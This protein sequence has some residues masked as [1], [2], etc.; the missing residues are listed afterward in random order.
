MK[1]FIKKRAKVL[2]LSLLLFC[3]LM[4]LFIIFFNYDYGKDKSQEIGITFSKSY[5]QQ[6]DLNWQE[7]YLSLLD[8]LQIK[9]VRLVAQWNEVEPTFLE[10]DFVDLDWQIK[11]AKKRGV[12]VVLAIGRRTPRWPE[13]HDPLWLENLDV[14]KVEQEQ[15]RMV[16][17]VV[18]HFKQFDNIKMCSSSYNNCQ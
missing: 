14:K 6:L 15:L 10:Y 3:L 2:I 9:N 13:C 16:E 5:A 4:F 18:E 17:D 7:A 12:E 11:E 1:N 8:D